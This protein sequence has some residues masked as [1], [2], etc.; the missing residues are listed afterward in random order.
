M[1]MLSGMIVQCPCV[2]I[3]ENIVLITMISITLI[4]TI[5]NIPSVQVFSVMLPVV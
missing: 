1:T 2:V 3:I 4:F 5:I